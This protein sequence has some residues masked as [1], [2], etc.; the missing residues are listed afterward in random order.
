MF[1]FCR[2]EFQQKYICC[3]VRVFLCSPDWPGVKSCFKLVILLS[4]TTSQPWFP[5]PIHPTSPPLCPVPPASTPLR[6]KASLPG[7]STKHGIT[8]YNKSR[9]TPSSHQGRTRQSSRK[10]SVPRVGR[11]VTTVPAPA[12]RILLRTPS[13]SAVRY[14]QGT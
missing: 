2:L 1:V 6:K 11:R 12:I 14:M 10:K 4:Y 8:N 9:H 13:S 5:S 3:R 7:T